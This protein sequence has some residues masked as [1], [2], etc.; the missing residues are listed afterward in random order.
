MIITE[1]LPSSW[2]FKWVIFDRYNT[3]SSKTLQYDFYCSQL[4]EVTEVILRAHNNHRPGNWILE[5]SV[6][7]ATFYPWQYHATSNMECWEAY[8]VNP[9]P[10]KQSSITIIYYQQSIRT[11]GIRAKPFPKQF[12]SSLFSL[13]VH[14]FEITVDADPSFQNQVTRTDLLMTRY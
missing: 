11:K 12:V 10:S 5:K 14:S 8:R 9:T 4:Y 2:V 7:G 3:E 13:L 6:D 1:I